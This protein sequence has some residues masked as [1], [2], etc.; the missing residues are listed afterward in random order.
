MSSNSSQGAPMCDDCCALVGASAATDA[1]EHLSEQRSGNLSGSREPKAM[2]V[3]WECDVPTC[4]S[5]WSR[6][7]ER[8]WLPWEKT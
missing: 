6:D 1:H 4:L 2:S 5:R 8:G 7:A 3:F